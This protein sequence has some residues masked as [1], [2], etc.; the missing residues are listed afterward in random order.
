MW[1]L[2][3]IGSHID[4]R[5]YGGM[6]GN[7]I[8]HYLIEFINFI[9]SNQENKAPT[10]I[11][12][13]M[14][15]FSKAFNRQNH[16]ILITKLS[17]MG[18]PAWLLKIVMAF[19]EDRTM[20]V[21]FNGATS[22]TKPLPGGGPQGTLLGL[23]L[24]IVL[25]N[26][27]GFKDQLNNAGDLISSR[28]NLRAANQIHLK[29]VDDL[30]VAES[31]IL[32]DN[33]YS[34]PDR[35]LPD[36]FRCRTGHAL[37]TENSAVY[38]EVNNIKEYAAANDMKLNLRKT[39]F[40]L[41]NQCKSIDF[42][43][44]LNI[45]GADIELVE[46]M[47]LLGVIITSDMKFSRNTEYI[48]E[49]GYKRVW[50]LRRLKNLGASD[51]QLVDVYIKQVRSVLEL[52]VPVWH[53]SLT[54]AD[55]ISIERV[56]KSALQ[57][58][59]GLEYDSYKS[60]CQHLGLETLEVRRKKLCKKFG[61]KAA[62]NAKHTKWFKVNTKISRTRQQQPQFC[63]VVSRTTRFDNSPLSYLTKVLNEHFQTK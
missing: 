26:D 31:L 32:K 60:A 29:F 34:V 14:V 11:L 1:L 45:D 62:K 37:K 17:D 15:D 40:M 6:K 5:Q 25:I 8:T 59:L 3:H 53:S 4:F 20:V 56:Q 21:R 13:C 51:Y 49:R 43:P 19:L 28:R 9:L 22:S 52:A 63:P 18:V 24:F 48:V 42:M 50:M 58:I 7:S 12:A 23:L 41:F 39:K 61:I 2:E 54:V 33:V 57:I 36:D 27:L 10:A 38:K 46:E 55:K 16:N 30:T 44:A 47:K 35:P